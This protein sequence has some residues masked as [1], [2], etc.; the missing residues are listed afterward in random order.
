M[1][2]S[3]RS[4]LR[5]QVGA[6]ALAALIVG[7]STTN[8]SDPKAGE[9]GGA[10]GA[11][12]GPACGRLTTPC[13]VGGACAGSADCA[14]QLC[15][16]G[17]C[18]AVVPADGVKNGDETDVDCGGTK[19][20]AC[21][22]T[23]GCALASDCKSGVCTNK[24]CQAPTSSDG[25]QNGNE[26]GVDCGGAGAPKCPTGTGCLVDGDCANVK[27]DTVQKKCASASHSDG[28]KN[29]G[30]TGVDCGGPSP[31][32]CATG[33]GCASNADCNAV[34]CDAAG[35][36]LCLAA[37]HVDGI[38]NLGETGI[39]C[40]GAA[41]AKCATGQGCLATTDCNKVLC[42]VA[43][44][45]L[46]LAA[47]HT[48]GI[49]NLGETGIDCGGAALPLTCGPGQGCAVLA[50]CTNT[51]CN[52]GTLVC[53]P[54]SKTDLIKNGTETDVDCGGG[55]PT[56]A[57]PCAVGRAC[58]ADD[59]NCLSNVC[60]YASKCVE[61]PSCRVQNGGDTCGAAGAN[62]SCCGSVTL[63]AS[64]VKIDKYE[65]TAGRMREF[66]RAVAN[67]VQAWVMTHPTAQIPAALVPFLPTGLDTPSQMV[68]EC[69]DP[70]GDFKNC[71]ANASKYSTVSQNFGVRQYLGNNV[72]MGD[73]PCPGCGVGLASE[74]AM[75]QTLR[76]GNRTAAGGWAGHRCA[77]PSPDPCR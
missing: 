71:S 29:D 21:V 50:D 44:T 20:P 41:P 6:L 36:K 16:G 73:R 2:I 62:E 31:T 61:A 9:D 17:A 23:K 55:A 13:D 51:L 30:E 60:N 15:T 57:G 47:S 39:D 3:L 65:I 32:K 35:T 33:E 74:W 28:L 8:E 11:V 43:G 49:L 40:G 56:N 4:S 48:D 64:A 18:A 68:S 66:I 7:C 12:P 22:D 27:C 63:P 37:T 46:C 70:S 38:T 53:D 72:F 59:A 42:D 10:D 76:P 19:A 14:S 45:K 26:T 69:N 5:S 67:N 52:A 25:V 58:G 24:I 75:S 1:P 77:S 34:A 54:P